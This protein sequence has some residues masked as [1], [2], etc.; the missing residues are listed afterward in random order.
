VLVET[1]R[2]SAGLIVTLYILVSAL[3][4]H[5][6]SLAPLTTLSLVGSV[7]VVPTLFGNAKIDY[8]NDPLSLHRQLLPFTDG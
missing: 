5:L 2:R 8:E 7:R 3:H 6:L 1:R 4:V